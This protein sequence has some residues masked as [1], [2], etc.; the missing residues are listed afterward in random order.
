MIKAIQIAYNADFALKCKIAAEAGFRHISV[1]FNDMQDN[2][3]AAFDRAPELILQILEENGLSCVQTH[4]PYYDL[5]I[6]VEELDGDFERRILR[7]IEAGGKIGAP[8]Q[9]YHP[10]S[11]VNAGFRRDVALQKNREVI[12]GYLAC[13]AKYNSGIALENLPIFSGIVPSMPFYSCDYGDLCELNDSFGAEN[14]GICWD[15]GH[16]NMMHF[17]QSAAIRYLGSRIK[18]THI[19]NNDSR[20]DQ[21]YP[22]DMGNISWK[23]IMEAFRS[24]DYQGPFTLETHCLYP[25]EN[26]LRSFAKHNF[27][28][29]VYMEGLC[30][31]K[32]ETI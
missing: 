9:V 10:R 1:N 4:L 11:A 6:S 20:K 16:A 15:T 27:A 8:W 24:V 5:R 32:E 18:C 23:P 2:S 25:E 31:Q 17:D 13:A 21:H 30:Q 12:E 26:L 29:L 19:H 14:V 22:P 28:G 3:D 7:S